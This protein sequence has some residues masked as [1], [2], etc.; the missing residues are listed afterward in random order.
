[1]GEFVPVACVGNETSKVVTIGVGGYDG[2]VDMEKVAKVVN[3]TCLRMAFYL[4]VSSTMPIALHH[5]S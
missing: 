3:R 4:M 1:V 2:S 5:I